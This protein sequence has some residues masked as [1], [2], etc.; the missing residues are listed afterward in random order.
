MVPLNNSG[1]LSA[2]E[3]QSIFVNWQDLIDCSNRL[4][5]AFIIRQRT[6]LNGLIQMIGDILCQHVSIKFN[7]AKNG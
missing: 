7:Y 2:D 4:V 3:L 6:C 5:K 1:L